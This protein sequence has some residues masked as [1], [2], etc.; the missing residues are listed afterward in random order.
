MLPSMVIRFLTCL[1]SANLL[2]NNIIN[3]GLKRLKSS[4]THLSIQ[5]LAQFITIYTSQEVQTSS[6]AKDDN[7][8]DKLEYIFSRYIDQFTIEEYGMICYSISCYYQN[9]Q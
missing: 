8:N 7:F 4:I 9:T 3:K 2:T 5:E 1:K 6:M